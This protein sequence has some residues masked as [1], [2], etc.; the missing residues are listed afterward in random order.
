MPKIQYFCKEQLI[1]E[2]MDKVSDKLKKLRQAMQNEALAACIIPSTDA[3]QSEYTADFAKFRAWMSGFTGSAGTLVVTQINAGL[4]TDSRY[5]LQAETELKNSGIDLYKS[6]L[7]G[8]PTLEAWIA[9]QKCGSVGIDGSVFSTKDVII[10]QK[11]LLESGIHLQTEFKPYIK[12][13]PNR[14]PRPENPIVAFP[15]LYSGESTQSKLSKLRC[16]M[17]IKDSDYLI[18]AML[19]EIAWAYNIRG[20]DIAYNPVALC[21]ACIGKDKAWIF[22]DTKKISPELI[23]QL[24]KEGIEQLPYD[25]F[26]AWISALQNTVVMLD[27]QKINFDI[28]NKIHSSCKIIDQPSPAYLLKGIKNK[29][30]LDGFKK[31][32]IKDGVALTRF[33][34]WLEETVHSNTVVDEYQVGLKIAA[35]RRNQDAYVSESFAPIVGLN[36]NGAI[37]HYEAAKESAKSM[38]PN[39]YL[40]I[41]TGGQYTHGTTD[42]TRTFCLGQTAEQDFKEDYTSILKGLIALSAIHFPKNTR[43]TQLDVLAR[44]FIWNRNINFLHGTGHGVGH[45]LNVHEGP[46]SI[47][48]NENPTLLQPGMV[49]TNEPGIYRTGKWGI[50]LENMLFVKELEVSEF[51]D[52]LAFETLTLFPFDKKCIELAALTSSEIAWINEYHE[53]TYQRLALHLTESEKIWLRKKTDS[54]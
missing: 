31:A 11:S 52:F 18:M 32:M 23:K 38:Q 7:P 41:D 13:W 9:A 49:V 19:D 29:T 17:H 50:R 54:L 15:E 20:G 37:I 36:G 14:P 22:A 33:L 35:F 47:R 28:F 1:Q 27:T 44:Q 24:S 26:P 34:M 42:I 40:L 46:H 45:F 2:T 21:Y 30:E 39:G 6:N 4:W 12:V 8:T 10:L 43:G 51:G 25:D 53:R 16:E 5:F 48:M 3:H